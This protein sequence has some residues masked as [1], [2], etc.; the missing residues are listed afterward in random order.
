MKERVKKLR[1]AIRIRRTLDVLDGKNTWWI[2][3]A[4]KLLG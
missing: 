2:R 3:I 4:Y 1:D